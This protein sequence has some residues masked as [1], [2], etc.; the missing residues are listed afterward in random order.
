[1]WNEGSERKIKLYSKGKI[2]TLIGGGCVFWN[3]KRVL[4]K[5]SML[6]LLFD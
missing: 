2:P 1:V 3:G 4:T 5:C 6:L